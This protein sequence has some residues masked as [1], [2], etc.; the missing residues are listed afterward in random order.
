MVSTEGQPGAEQEV[1]A[2]PGHA[3]A[4]GAAGGQDVQDVVVAALPSVVTALALQ[5]LDSLGALVKLG[6]AAALGLALWWLLRSRGRS[7]APAAAS[8]SQS[9]AAAQV[10]EQLP[11][12]IAAAPPSAPAQPVP[13][14]TRRG[15]TTAV[16][17][18]VGL[19]ALSIVVLVVAAVAFGRP[20]WPIVAVVAVGLGV[21]LLPVVRPA[22]VPSVL[23]LP[24][25]A[26]VAGAV[27]GLG[28]ASAVAGAKNADFTVSADTSP[29][30][31]TTFDGLRYPLRAVGDFWA[32]RSTRG[33]P[34]A[35]VQLRLASVHHATGSAVEAVGVAAQFGSVRVLFEGVPAQ[36]TIGGRPALGNGPWQ[37]DGVLLTRSGSRWITTAP[38]GEV[39]TVDAHP[40]FLDWTLKP[41]DNPT[42]LYEGLLGN[43]DEIRGNDLH[44]NGGPMIEPLAGPGTDTLARINGDF[45]DSWRVPGSQ[46]LLP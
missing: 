35:E 37:V 14:R 19:A 17:I 13:S 6:I 30:S 33:G 22:G 32:A 42:T 21:L 5:A 4:A 44:V 23:A 41:V 24:L 40:D 39:L 8:A 20:T 16:Q 9:A 1:L 2:S 36:V 29:T 45:A 28:V 25:A 15:L 38:T 43:N 31:V 10:P 3:P 46:Q 26:A 34:T 11:A 18:L 27:L 7:K 12:E